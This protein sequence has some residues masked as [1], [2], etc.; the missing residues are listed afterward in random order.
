MMPVPL[1]FSSTA[2]SNHFLLV[3]N[4]IV[5]AKR[6]SVKACARQG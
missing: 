1:S 5:G 3:R 4:M 6:T 2:A